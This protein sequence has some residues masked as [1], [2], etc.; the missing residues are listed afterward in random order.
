MNGT[1]LAWGAF[2][3]THVYEVT[4]AGTGAAIAV[5]YQDCNFGDNSGSLA[6]EIIGPAS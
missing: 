4:F 6:L 1:K 3:P 5:G 2:S